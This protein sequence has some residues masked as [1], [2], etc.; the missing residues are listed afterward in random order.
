M[1]N[2]GYAKFWGQVRCVMGDV[3]LTYLGG[4]ISSSSV[5]TS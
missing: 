3:Q 5:H 1:K 2:K 4:L